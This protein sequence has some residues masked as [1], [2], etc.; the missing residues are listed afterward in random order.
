[1]AYNT[2]N[3]KL[4]LEYIKQDKY[5]SVSDIYNELT[6][7]GKKI[8]KSTI[9]RYIDY[10]EQEKLIIRH[11][12]TNTKKTYLQY[13][14]DNQTCRGHLHMKCKECGLTVHL[15]TDLLTKTEELHEFD[16][17]YDTSIIQGT[18]KICK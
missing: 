3:R 7:R 1:M 13:V 11:I 6:N 17:E 18:C 8:N 14:G 16:V 12:D 15:P 4:I 10:L 9:Y 2:Q 5:V